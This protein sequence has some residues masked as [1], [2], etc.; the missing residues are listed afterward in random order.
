MTRPLFAF[1]VGL[2]TTAA[3]LGDG[4]PPP[5]PGKTLVRADYVITAAKAFPDHDFY[6][7]TGR[8]PA[9]VPFGPDA[10]VKVSGVRG[11]KLAGLVE[12]MAVPK[13]AAADY[14]SADA[15][16][17]ALAAKKVP[18]Q[19]VADNPLNPLVEIDAKDTRKTLVVTLAVEKIDAK[20]GIVLVP[21][22]AAEKAAPA[23][24]SPPP[25]GGAA[26]AALA[27]ALG[28]AFAGVW[29]ARRGR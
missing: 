27:A 7:V 22:K 3:A 20:A 2:L 10:P 14:T 8:S 13:G 15:F 29:L 17:E 16:A 5:T 11:R 19:A 24:T 1:A 4:L 26:V 23:P 21:A 6:V 28:L 12:F 9:K 25:A 18:G